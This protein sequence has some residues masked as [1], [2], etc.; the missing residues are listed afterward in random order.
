MVGRNE[1]VIYSWVVLSVVI[2]NVSFI[3]KVLRIE[4]FYGEKFLFSF[5]WKVV[6]NYCGV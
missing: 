2:V 3:Y 5:K 1:F 6:Y 4:L